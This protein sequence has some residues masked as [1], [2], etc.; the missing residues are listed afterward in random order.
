[1]NKPLFWAVV[2]LVCALTRRGPGLFAQEE[3]VE[4][5]SA[6]ET[7]VTFNSRTDISILVRDGSPAPGLKSGENREWALET[8]GE[9]SLRIEFF[10]TARIIQRLAV[11]TSNRERDAAFDSTVHPGVMESYVAFFPAPG[12]RISAGILEPSF[13]NSL[14]LNPVDWLSRYVAD[15]GIP[16]ASSFPGVEGRI[17]IGEWTISVT[18]LPALPDTGLGLFNEN[19]ENHFGAFTAS[20]LLWDSSISIDAF[21]EARPDFSAIFSGAAIETQIPF[22]E[23]LSV[24]AQA[25]VSNGK[26]AFAVAQG[27]LALLPTQR[28]GSEKEFFLDAALYLE[29]SLASFFNVGIGYGYSGRGISAESLLR[30]RTE[31]YMPAAQAG[32][33]AVLPAYASPLSWPPA[34]LD[35]I[36]FCSLGI[37]R[38]TETVGASLVAFASP[39]NPSAWARLALSWTPLESAQIDLSVETPL[40]EEGSLFRPFRQ[41][42]TIAITCAFSL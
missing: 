11:T 38:I 21:A 37:P 32:L 1:M 3:S 6:V 33:N 30:L 36:L 22:A 8:S 41:E 5:P 4:K 28:D 16:G 9:L 34:F 29:C 26:K 39:L 40:G 13:G 31:G 18:V 20:G 7:S 35:H 2:G 15:P 25:L 24:D 12:A 23:F 27:P 14:F 10:H 17:P 42:A 19:P